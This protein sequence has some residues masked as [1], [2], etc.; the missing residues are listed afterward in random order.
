MTTATAVGDVQLRIAKVVGLGAADDQPFHQD[1][2]L[3][4]GPGDQPACHRHRPARGVQPGRS[5]RWDH[6]AASDDRPGRRRPGTGPWR[7][8]P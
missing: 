7:A 6:L 4:E 2:V 8:G 3:E 5:S 1:V